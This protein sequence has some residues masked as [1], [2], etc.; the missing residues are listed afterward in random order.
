MTSAPSAMSAAASCRCAAVAV[1]VY[2]TPQWGTT[3]TTSAPAARAACDVGARPRQVQRCSA[4]TARRRPGRRQ[5]DGVEGQDRDADTVDGEPGRCIRRVDVRACAHRRE[6]GRLHVA[7]RLQHPG[8]AGVADVVVGQRDDVHARVVD[9]GLEGR[10]EGERE[11]ARVIDEVVRGGALV[12][13]ERQVGVPEERRDRAGVTGAH[14]LHVCQP[15]TAAGPAG[16][17]GRAAVPRK[18]RAVSEQHRAAVDLPIVHHVAGRGESPDGT[19]VELGCARHPQRPRLERTDPGLAEEGLAVDRQCPHGRFHVGGADQAEHVDATL[20]GGHRRRRRELLHLRPRRD[21]QGVG[22]GRKIGC[23]DD[24]PGEARILAGE[25]Q[26]QLRDGH[27]HVGGPEADH[28]DDRHAWSRGG[29]PRRRGRR[30]WQGRRCPGAR[31][32]PCGQAGSR[33]GAGGTALRRQRDRD[34]RDAHADHHEEPH[35]GGSE[36]APDH[37]RCIM[38][39]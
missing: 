15:V 1:D 27:R 2:S 31:R 14:G 23:R 38:Q 34:D 26:A 24:D 19:G 11:S 36:R 22:D 8:R 21:A 18:V 13:D 35:G 3:M 33:R 6:A 10:V 5:V 29:G 37:Q 28:G 25:G 20:H 16:D 39:P 7:D 12:I 32:Q 9:A 4:G 30:R 17:H